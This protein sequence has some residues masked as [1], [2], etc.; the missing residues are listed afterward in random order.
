MHVPALGYKVG[1]RQGQRTAMPAGRQLEHGERQAIT[2]ENA[3][4]RVAVDK[5]TGCITSLMEKK[6]KFEMVAQG[7]CGN[8]LQFFKDTPKDYDA[9]NVDPGTLD[10]APRR[11]RRRSRWR[12]K[13]SGA[14]RSG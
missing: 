2:L 5:S 11:L 3:K 8:Q 6:S 4:V 1:A 14:P 10:A 13:A 9:W 7:A 12:L